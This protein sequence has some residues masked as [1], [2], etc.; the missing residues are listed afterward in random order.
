[1]NRV[2]FMII[3]SAII[4]SGC[5]T[6]GTQESKTEIVKEPVTPMELNSFET[7]KLQAPNLECGVALMTAAKDR[8]SFREFEETNLSLKHLSELL[9]MANGVNREDGK[10]TVPSARA[11]YPLELYAVL[12]NGIYFYD[13]VEHELQPIVEGDYRNLSG[14]QPFVDNAPLNLVFIANYE[15]YIELNMPESKWLYLAALDAGH[16][17]QNIYLY[18]ASEGLKS[19]VRA[20]AKEEELLEVLKL[21]E[22]YQF[23]VAHTVGY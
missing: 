4:L 21:G 11:L 8:M 23:V 3:V 1:M 12:A 16:C 17:T 13:P 14:L 7:I 9:W 22:N 6:S 20:G 19:V 2:I 10:R 5:C 15:K 18:C